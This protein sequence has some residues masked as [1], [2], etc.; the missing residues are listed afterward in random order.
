MEMSQG[1][2]ETW[3]TGGHVE[4][5]PLLTHDGEVTAKQ[6]SAA[7]ELETNPSM[8]HSSRKLLC[9][10]EEGSWMRDETSSRE[11]ASSAFN[12]SGKQEQ[13]AVL[14]SCVDFC[15]LLNNSNQTSDPPI[16]RLILGPPGHRLQNW[17]IPSISCP[18]SGHHMFFF[19]SVHWTPR[20]PHPLF[21]PYSTTVITSSLWPCS[22][23]WALGRRSASANF[24]TSEKEK[25]CSGLLCHSIP[26]TFYVS[27][28]IW[29]MCLWKDTLL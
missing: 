11:N 7:S 9:S 17:A 3:F 1:C 22:H 10:A 26:R 28:D 15:C 5:W 27:P 13:W 18:P 6:A 25:V 29:L 8:L 12:L 20:P 4:S 19:L 24:L 21:P 23:S 16:R 14:Q 2:E